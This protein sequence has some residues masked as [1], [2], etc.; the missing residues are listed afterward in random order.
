MKNANQSVGKGSHIKMRWK[1]TYGGLTRL[2]GKE[3]KN[4]GCLFLKKKAT[5]GEEG[6]ELLNW[7]TRDWSSRWDEID[8]RLPKWTIFF[9]GTKKHVPMT[10]GG[11][12]GSGPRRQ[13]LHTPTNLNAE[14][15]QPMQSFRSQSLHA[16][17]T[18]LRQRPRF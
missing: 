3:T 6:D 14:Q 12:L 4:V 7:V 1:V 18:S 13:K 8:E 2:Q 16:Y 10:R 11:V 15:F 17:R 9:G 5:P